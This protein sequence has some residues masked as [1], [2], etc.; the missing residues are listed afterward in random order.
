MQP[1]HQDDIQ[2]PT[3]WL[4]AITILVIPG[5]WVLYIPTWRIFP[6]KQTIVGFRPLRIGLGWVVPLPHGHA[7]HHT[8]RPRCLLVAPNLHG[9]YRPRDDYGSALPAEPIGELL[10]RKRCG[11]G[12]KDFWFSPRSLGND[13]IWR[14]YFSIGLKPATSLGFQN[15][16]F[17]SDAVRIESSQNYGKGDPLPRILVSKSALFPNKHHPQPQ[18]NWLFFFFVWYFSLKVT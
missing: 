10:V 18:P 7:W 5:P 14:S 3:N 9:E 12:F 1:H 8:L 11:S 17:S 13:Q 2:K 15:W 16:S 4:S 6:V